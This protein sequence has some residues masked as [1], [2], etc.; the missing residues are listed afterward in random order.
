[1][2]TSVPDTINPLIDRIL[3]NPL[4]F[5]PAK[6][7][8]RETETSRPSSYIVLGKTPKSTKK[9]ESKPNSDIG[10][11]S[12]SK[13]VSQ[14]SQDSM[15]RPK[16][17]A[18]AVAAYTGKKY[19]TKAEKKKLKKDKKLNKQQSTDVRLLDSDEDLGEDL[20]DDNS[21]LIHGAKHSHLIEPNTP[22]GGVS[23]SAS[24]S[25]SQYES[26]SEYP[27]GDNQT[28][29]SASSNNASTDSLPFADFKS[30]SSVSISS[31]SN[32]NND[33]DDD[34]SDFGSADEKDESEGSES[35]S[36]ADSPSAEDDDLEKLKEDLIKDA[37]DANDQ[38]DADDD[39][40]DAE[41]KDEEEVSKQ[42]SPA[43]P[44]S[45]N[46]T[47]PTSPEDANEQTNA[48][49]Q[50]KQVAD[51]VKPTKSQE[52]VYE[53]QPSPPLEEFYRINENPQDRGL[54]NSNRILK[55][56]NKPL[57]NKKPV[58]LLNHGVTC[59]MN[60]AIQAI[61]HVPAV[62]HYLNDVSRG[63]YD[64]VLKPRSVTHVLSELSQRMWG[65]ESNNKDHQVKKIKHPKYINP[66][67]I[68]QRLEDINCMMSEWN[69]EDSHEYFMSLMSRLQE[70][71]TPKGVKLNQS[72]IYD[73]FGGLLNQSVTC[74]NCN[75]ES[76]TKQEFYDLSLGLNKKKKSNPTNNEQADGKSSKQQE[77]ELSIN[78][79]YSI[80][81]SIK[82]FF[83]TE[84]IKL[85]RKDKSSGYFC[86]KCSNRSV[87]TKKS[88]IDRSPETLIIHLKRFKFNGNSSSKVKQSVSYPKYL[89]LT[90]F[91]T[92]KAEPSRYQLLSVIVH[93]GRSISSGHYVAH[94]LQPDG[95][96]DRYDDEYINRLN[97]RQALSDPSAYFLLY[98]KLTPKTTPK[99]NGDTQD[100]PKTKK[101]KL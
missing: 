96:W 47:P 30:E 14:E 53:K 82:E 2:S 97:E 19:L 100:Q 4:T 65:V 93:E 52:P 42:S 56:W 58:G 50:N 34:D 22:T 40:E 38:D 24:E 79:R 70:D 92:N 33:Q 78:N 8:D 88:T 68:I 12:E 6:K 91:T 63:K 59:Y 25:E 90:D 83:A 55:N 66:K 71:S 54:N 49:N 60:S 77:T 73:I 76:I 39:E 26:A 32:E 69:Q 36:N 17:M 81:K 15:R 10:P 44:S 20:N 37:F 27:S 28:L 61:L 85:D 87:A 3:A 48:D 23:P 98:T 64:K 99:R 67:K 1:M 7:T 95:N 84:M 29:L 89:D 13:Q 80:E 62:Q 45:T 5:V 57:L 9:A 11:D 41:E 86:E 35:E 31:S 72:I 74:Q 43:K 51:D 16:S 94:C 75:H 18:E 46:A 21:E 101:R